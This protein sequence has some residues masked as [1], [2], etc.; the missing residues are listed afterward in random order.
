MFK[1]SIKII[2]FMLLFLSLLS[3]TTYMLRGESD[4]KQRFAGFYYQPRDTLDV[5]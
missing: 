1:R 5:I 4:I 3:E 2:C